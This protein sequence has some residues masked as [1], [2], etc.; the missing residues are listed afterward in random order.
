MSQEAEFVG[1]EPCPSC[2]SK[3]NLARYTDGHGYCFGCQ[4]YQSADGRGRRA[5]AP[6]KAKAHKGIIGTGEYT[7]LNKRRISE[8][9]CKKFGY[10]ISTFAGRT[11]QVAAYRTEDRVVTAQK[12]RFADK[13]FTV[14]GS[15]SDALPLWGQHLWRDGGRK[16]VITE[17]EIDAMSVSQVQGNKWPVVSL[18][19]GAAGAAKAVAKAVKW[20][21]KFEDVVLMFDDDEPGRAAAIE[22]AQV[23][24]PGKA[25]IGNIEGYKDAN[26]ALQAGSTDVIISAIWSAKPYRPDGIVSISDIREAVMTPIEHGYPWWL[27]ALT[28]ATFGRRPGEVYT[29]GAGTG[30]GKTDMFTQQAAFDVIKLEK[31][32]GMI[33]LEMPPVELGRRLAGKVAEQVFHL[34]PPDGE[35]DDQQDEL[36]C[37]LDLLDDHVFIY[38]HWGETEW[39]VISSTVRH[40]VKADGVEM[41]YLD[42]LTALADPDDERA[43]LERIMKDIASLAQELKCII[44]LISHLATPDGKSHEE[45]GRVTI[46]HFKGSRSIGFW[47]F[48]M[49]GLERDQQSEDKDERKVTTVRVLKERLTGRGVG[50]TIPLTYDEKRGM[51]HEVDPGYFD[52]QGEGDYGF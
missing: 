17:G 5:C 29:F 47:S 10:S 26:E 42:H 35:F 43:S 19:N 30:V 24:P 21:S 39:D 40:M 36:A 52:S 38:D 8:E 32:V 22:C 4:H 25:K 41:I 44:H 37:A 50:V 27:P 7:P 11:V 20:L 48:A 12:L 2:G 28:D 34:P 1:H 18:P 3:D 13:G 23:L 51:L 16:V 33:Y 14:R 46:R 31:K 9:T 49:I 6:S 15:L 45:G